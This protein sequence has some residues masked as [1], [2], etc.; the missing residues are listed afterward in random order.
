MKI[1]NFILKKFLQPTER[2]QRNGTKDHGP[3]SSKEEKALF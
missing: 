1:I 3:L 2:E